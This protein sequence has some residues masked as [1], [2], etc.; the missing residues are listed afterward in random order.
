MSFVQQMFG[1]IIAIWIIFIIKI[2]FFKK[3]RIAG[4]I[5]IISSTLILLKYCYSEIKS[6]PPNINTYKKLCGLYKYEEF[7]STIKGQSSYNFHFQLNDYG[8]Y[9]YHINHTKAVHYRYDGSKK[10]RLDKLR[11]NQVVCLHVSFNTYRPDRIN[12]LL[13]I[14][15]LTS[16]YEFE[17]QK[18]CGQQVATEYSQGMTKSKDNPYHLIFKLDNYG[19]YSYYLPPHVIT[20]S[21]L[22][23]DVI[24]TNSN[25]DVCLIAKIPK[26]SVLKSN[27]LEDA[28]IL[29]IELV[30]KPPILKNEQP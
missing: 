15:Y 14:E 17:F 20:R 10:L 4:I 28:D 19:T 13:D 21:T 8:N 6:L 1:F 12:E 24:Y 22:I 3:T 29:M 16:D 9:A 7:L 27:F 25:Q 23:G 18:I 5:L 11:N 2:T 26:V 30:D